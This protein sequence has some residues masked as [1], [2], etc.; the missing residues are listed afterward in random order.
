MPDNDTRD[1]AKALNNKGIIEIIELKGGLSISTNSYVG[2]IKLGELQINVYSK[3]NGMPLYKLNYLMRPSMIY[4]I[5]N[6]L[7]YL[8]MNFMLKQRTCS[9]EGFKRAILSREKTYLVS[10]YKRMVIYYAVAYI[11][12]FFLN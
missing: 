3:I 8:F 2:R 5:L 7:T 1:I 12:A 4:V 6:S 9:I 11:R 10:I